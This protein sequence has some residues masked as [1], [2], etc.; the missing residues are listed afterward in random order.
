[1]DHFPHS[2]VR[3]ILVDGHVDSDGIIEMLEAVLGFLNV[4]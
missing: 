1:M 3:R 4:R 2:Y